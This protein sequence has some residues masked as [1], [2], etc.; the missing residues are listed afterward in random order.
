MAKRAEH[1]IPGSHFGG[2]AENSASQQSWKS[3]NSKEQVLGCYNG[4]IE[5]LSKGIKDIQSISAKNQKFERIRQRCLGDVRQLLEDSQH[6]MQQ[7]INETVW[8]KLVIAFFGETNAGKS[9]IIETFRV[10]YNDP[11]RQ[12]AILNN[13]GRGVDGLIVGDGRPDFTQI[14]SKYNLEIDRRPFVLIDVPGIEG[15]EANYLSEISSALKQAH[16]IFYVQGHNKKPDAATAKKIKGFLSD[17]VDVYSI[18]NVRGSVSDYD[19]EEERTTLITPKIKERQESI[20]N[21]FEAVLAGVYKGNVTCQGYLALMSVADFHESRVK[22]ISDQEKIIHFFGGRENVESF[23]RFDSISDLVKSKSFDF[24]N[25]ILE[26]NRQKLHSLS[27]KIHAGIENTITSQTDNLESLISQ[28]REFK[29]NVS[30]IRNDVISIMNSRLYSE[31]NQAFVALKCAANDIIDD[32]ATEKEWKNRITAR[33]NSITDAFE[34]EIKDIYAGTLSLFKERIE[35]KRKD[36]DQILYSNRSVPKTTIRIKVD[37]TDIID[38]LVF[39]IK[40]DLFKSFY[41]A[42]MNPASTL[43]KVLFSR[44]NNDGRDKAKSLISSK[45]ESA[46]ASVWSQVDDGAAKIQNHL[47]QEAR[48]IIKGIEEEIHNIKELESDL[49]CL[50]NMFEQ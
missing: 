37:L 31:L 47:K 29:N 10:K 28:L 34:H 27:C 24:N 17:W 9:T 35:V 20:K 7:V 39:D 3:L 15:K 23:S 19:E 44:D 16:C 33:F 41:K 4:Y 42:F 2:S 6:Q 49:A 22:L 25:Q 30:S 12:A 1:T 36:L 40:E 26:A 11:S 14:Y 21:V 32:A 18:Y 50:H 46:K 45:L 8:D 5:R 43:I 38:A 13:S 48:T